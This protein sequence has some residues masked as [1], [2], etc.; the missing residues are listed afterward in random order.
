MTT[1]TPIRTDKRTGSST[2]HAFKKKLPLPFR[3]FLVL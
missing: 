3:F 1:L 2:S